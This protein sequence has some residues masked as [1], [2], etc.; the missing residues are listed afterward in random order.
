MSTTP[1]VKTNYGQVRGVVKVTDDGK[2]Y[3]S[4]QGIF[5]ATQPRGDLR[6]RD[7]TPLE[8]WDDIFDAT[9][10]GQ[11]AYN[12]DL[13]SVVGAPF[14]GGDDCLTLNVYTPDLTPAK[15]LP[16]MV[17]IH[18]GGFVCGS[19]STE[20]YGPDFVVEK[21]VILV[22]V[23]YRLDVFGFLSFKDPEIGIPGNAGLKDQ[24]MA[25]KWVKENISY[26]GG[27]S[28]NITLSG[29]SAGSAST[30]YQMVSPLSK[31]LFNRAIL[32]SAT[33]LCGWAY[34]QPNGVNYEEELAKKLGWDGTG[35][36]KEIYRVIA[37]TE[38]AKIAEI[39][40]NQLLV[41]DKDV[42]F[43][44]A[45]F[46]PFLPVVEPYKSRLCFLPKTPFELG[47]E[48]WSKDLDIIIGGVSDEGIM[49]WEFVEEAHMATL[50]N[51][52]EFFLPLKVRQKTSDVTK[53]Q[54]KAKILKEAYYGEQEPTMENGPIFLDYQSEKLFWHD[55]TR[56]LKQRF[57]F[58]GKGKNYVYHLKADADPGL[59][60]HV[61][62]RN[63]CK[64]PHL[65]GFNHGD[66]LPL[67]FKGFYNKKLT[68]E[69]PIYLT[70]VRYFNTLINFVKTGD[71]NHE[72]LDGVKWKETT[73]DD[74]ELLSLNID[75]DKVSFGV[76]P[77]S[78]KLKAWDAVYDEEDLY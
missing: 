25:L 63:L 35:G 51:N 17:W 33:S 47:R 27:D 23:N 65:K 67:V 66:E 20:Y 52:P 21:D 24:S 13:Y 7:P 61:L 38:P 77:I 6:F 26:F 3:N 46:A 5:Y 30:H 43:G 57:Y 8:P 69:S 11:V 54:T 72:S 12:Y 42:V 1:I 70:F 18:G 44:T 37:S 59:E 19:G 34:R 32:M 15:P 9:K 2:Q 41:R 50:R 53:L 22:T 56:T 73:K 68:P 49:F 40:L 64:V 60:L 31:G 48:A 28:D 10:E 71:P 62:W 36:E 14:T 78:D 55:I 16:V 39:S 74:T 4:F 29:E 75:G 45:L 58:G 76:V